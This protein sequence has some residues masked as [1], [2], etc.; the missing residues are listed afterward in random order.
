[1]THR[2]V[3]RHNRLTS[4]RYRFVAAVCIAAVFL[5]AVTPVAASLFS[6]VLIP[7]PALFG[8]VVC[9]DAPAPEVLSPEPFPTDAPLPSRAPPRA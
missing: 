1:V 3:R 2:P 8:A 6:A 7:L 5:A 4:G 9:F